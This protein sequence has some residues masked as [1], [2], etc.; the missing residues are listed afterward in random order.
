MQR[1]ILGSS[2]RWRAQ[3][4]RDA[5]YE[6]LAIAPDIDEKAIRRDDPVQLTVAIAKAKAAA[7]LARIERDGGLP[8]GYEDALLVTSDQ[9]VQMS[10]GEIMAV[11][12]KPASAQEAAMMLGSYGEIG[13]CV[14]VTSLVTTR[15]RTG[16]RMIGVD[17][18]RVAFDPIPEDRIAAAI[19]RGDVL[20]SCGAFT[21]EDPDIAP[22]IRKVYGTKDAVDGMPL[23]LLERHIASLGA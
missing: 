22:F 18:A 16:E 5:G 4:L 23:Y 19:A 13:F 3:V 14:T 1:L 10:L 9:V 2:S 12:E 6:F 20:G 11:Y 8:R 21:H 7:V 17:F 15:I